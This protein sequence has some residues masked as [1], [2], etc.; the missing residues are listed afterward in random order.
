MDPAEQDQAFGRI[1]R[2]G[3]TK[4]VELVQLMSEGTIE[5]D[6]NKLCEYRRA[7]KSSLGN[8]AEL[9]S[10]VEIKMLMKSVLEIK[11]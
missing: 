4:D 7:G 10:N 1:H 5:E 11:C 6:M 8:A 9:F 3:Q 2:L